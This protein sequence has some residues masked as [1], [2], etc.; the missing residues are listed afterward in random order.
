MTR[1]CCEE[2]DCK[3][4]NCDVGSFI[5]TLLHSD[6]TILSALDLRD[7]FQQGR[8]LIAQNGPCGLPLTF[9]DIITFLVIEAYCGKIN[10]IES[11]QPI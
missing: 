6:L 11:L 8:R 4:R 5:L 2:R 1:V 10:C 7:Q 3:Y 9:C